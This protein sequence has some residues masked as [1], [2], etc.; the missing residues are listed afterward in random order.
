MQEGHPIAYLSKPLSPRNQALSTYEKECVAIL[1]AIEKWR[2][3][4]QHQKFSI[5]TDNISLLHITEQRITSKLQHKALMKLMDLNFTLHYKKGVSNTAADS[6]SRCYTDSAVQA[7]SACVPSWLTK[8][9]EGYLDDPQAQQLL[10]ELSISP[11]STNGYSLVDG[12]IR[13]RGRV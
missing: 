10:T 6:L 3:Y 5:F 12:I 1:M 8:L 2:P 11:D 9:Q 7:V 13:Y 4:L